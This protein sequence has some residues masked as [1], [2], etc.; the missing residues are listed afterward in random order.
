MMTREEARAAAASLIGNWTYGDDRYFG[1]ELHEAIKCLSS[2]EKPRKNLTASQPKPETAEDGVDGSQ[3]PTKNEPAVN[4]CISEFVVT[5]DDERPVT[6]R[7]ECMALVT[8]LPPSSPEF[9]RKRRKLPDWCY[10]Q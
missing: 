5:T 9:S 3:A 2:D 4:S 8:V 1:V 7:L 10:Q 6:C